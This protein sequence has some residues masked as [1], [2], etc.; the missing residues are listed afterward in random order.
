MA[1]S[2]SFI[3][4]VVDR[5]FTPD[6]AKTFN[7]S[8]YP[9]FIVLNKDQEKVHRFQAYMKPPDFIGQ[10]GEGLKR[11]ALY[12]SGQEWDEANPRAQLLTVEA[13]VTTMNAPLNKVPAGI[14]FLK[15]DMWVAYMGTLYQLDAATGAVKKNF[16]MDGSILDITSDGKVLYGM[17]SGWTAG[18]P[19]HVIDPATGKD[20]RQIVTAAN[21]ENKSYGAKGVTWLKGKLYVLEFYGKIFEV[22]PQTGVVGRTITTKERSVSGLD[23]D[24][25][26][27]VFGSRTDLILIN[28]ETG[29]TVRKVPVN[30]PLRFVKFW[31]GTYYTMEQPIF[32]FSKDHKTIQVWPRQAKIYR[33]TLPPVPAADTRPAS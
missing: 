24:G 21:K 27:F 33:L 32:G 20:L 2:R 4:V 11:Y 7:V 30:Y 5:D 12:S 28:P 25:E 6:L 29:A 8:A 9:S 13:T 16:E 26:H 15:G 22:D 3:W 18:K 1:A 17:E 19:I 14:A 10:L 23:F 31:K